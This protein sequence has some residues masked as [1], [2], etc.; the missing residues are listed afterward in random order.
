LDNDGDGLTDEAPLDCLCADND[1]NGTADT[2]YWILVDKGGD[3]TLGCAANANPVWPCS[4]LQDPTRN[5]GCCDSNGNTVSCAADDVEARLVC[6]GNKPVGSTYT[7]IP[8]GLTG[9]TFDGSVDNRCGEASGA[10]LNY[11]LRT[12]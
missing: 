11:V 6:P 9:T 2:P 5:F 3:N 7:V 8:A 12:R 1:A 4:L 10:G